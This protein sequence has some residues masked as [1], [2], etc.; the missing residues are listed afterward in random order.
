MTEQKKKRMERAG[1]KGKVPRKIGRN[2]GLQFSIRG[3]GVTWTTSGA[4][5]CILS[6]FKGDTNLIW[7][8]MI[9]KVMVMTEGVDKHYLEEF[10]RTQQD[11][12][13]LICNIYIFIIILSIRTLLIYCLI[14]GLTHDFRPLKSLKGVLSFFYS[15]TWDDGLISFPTILPLFF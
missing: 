11:F 14:Y 12:Y 6:P 3:S 5:E 4:T 7:P 10:K 2:S 8:Y 15:I 13:L 1:E 9:C